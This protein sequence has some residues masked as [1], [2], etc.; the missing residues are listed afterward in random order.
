MEN[1]Q[2]LVVILM[3]LSRK[4]KDC[5]YTNLLTKHSNIQVQLHNTK[6]DYPPFIQ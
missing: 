3:Y 2:N 1:F 5:I 6:R 4:P